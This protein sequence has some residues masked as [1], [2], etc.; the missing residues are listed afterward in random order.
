MLY[1]PQEAEPLEIAGQKL[2]EHYGGMPGVKPS[3]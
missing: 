2:E 3:K 1:V